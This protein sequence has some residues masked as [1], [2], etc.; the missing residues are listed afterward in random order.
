[1]EIKMVRGSYVAHFL[2]IAKTY[3]RAL[4]L[5]KKIGG[6]RYDKNDFGGGIVFHSATDKKELEELILTVSETRVKGD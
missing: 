1:M 2:G 4:H 5:A 3:E 6:K